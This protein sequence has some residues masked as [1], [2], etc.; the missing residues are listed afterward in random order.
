MINEYLKKN[1]SEIDIKLQPFSHD[2]SLCSICLNILLRLNF[3]VISYDLNYSLRVDNDLFLSK[4]SYG[5][6]KKIK[7]CLRGGFYV[8]KLDINKYDEAYKVIESN[9]KS[10]GYPMTMDLSAFLEMSRTFPDRIHCFAVFNPSDLSIIAASICISIN[11]D[12]L[13]VFY[14]GDVLSNLSYSPITFLASKIYDFAKENS[15][16][17]LDIGTSS[18]NSNPNYGLINFKKNMGF[19]ESMKLTLEFKSS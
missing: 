17:T 13:Y 5:N 3:S 15:Y 9:R 11:S 12:I 18:I 4:V 19:E 8:S 6:R 14:W 10:K 7:Q 1:S 2:I 16:S